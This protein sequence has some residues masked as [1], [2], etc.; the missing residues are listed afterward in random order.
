MKEGT[1]EINK[2]DEQGDEVGGESNNQPEKLQ[3][4]L[5]GVFVKKE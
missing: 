3:R 1:R 4:R 2:V 5:E